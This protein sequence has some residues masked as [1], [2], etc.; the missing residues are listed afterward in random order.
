MFLSFLNDSVRVKVVIV[1][2]RFTAQ[3]TLDDTVSSIKK[4][5]ITKQTRKGL[6]HWASC[7]KY[8][9]YFFV[10]SLFMIFV[11][12]CLFLCD[13]K[14]MNQEEG[15]N[16][17]FPGKIVASKICMPA[18][19][20]FEAPRLSTWRS[21]TKGPLL[22]AGK[23]GNKAGGVQPSLSTPKGENSKCNL[24]DYCQ[25]WVQYS[26]LQAETPL[27]PLCFTKIDKGDRG[28]QTSLMCNSLFYRSQWNSD[29]KARMIT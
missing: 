22:A 25:H 11:Y 29:P 6:H 20:S 23:L 27:S 10:I 26:T 16:V 9:K 8:C 18:I 17:Y 5:M 4:H 19:S 1:M 7:V 21:W 28:M 24:W 13:V 14:F 12:E 2:W 3:T 15:K